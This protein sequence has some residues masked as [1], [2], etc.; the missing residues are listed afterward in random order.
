V[1][2][3]LKAREHVAFDAATLLGQPTVRPT[4]CSTDGLCLQ[5]FLL[6]RRD[7]QAAHYPQNASEPLL[8]AFFFNPIT[9]PRWGFNRRHESDLWDQNRADS[10]AC[11]AWAK[12]ATEAD[13]KHK[14]CGNWRHS[15]DAETDAN[16]EEMKEA[17]QMI[18]EPNFK[19]QGCSTCESGATLQNKGQRSTLVGRCFTRA[20]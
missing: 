12:M 4:C 1:H 13:W 8:H 11:M 5:V 6:R 3:L 10:T 16:E 7:V 17:Q 19:M 14:R 20:V 15:P 9:V 18:V 2:D